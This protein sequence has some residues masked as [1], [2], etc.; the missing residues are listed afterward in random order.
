MDHSYWQ[1]Q[2][3]DKPLFPDLLWSRPENRA[4]AGKL[5]IVGGNAH[6][7]AAAAEAYALANSA[8]A[9]KIRVLL[10][11]A[12]QK[13]VGPMF[14]AGE[15]APSTPSG[16]FAQTALG[17]LLPMAHW[18]DG[19]LLAGD[20]GRN[21]ETAILIEKFLT[22]HPGQ[23]TLTKDAIEY[24]TSQPALV[25]ERANTLLVLSFSQLQKLAVELKF[26]IAFTSG[27]D[28]LRAVDALHE[29][30]G[31]FPFA[32]ITRH[33]DN[34]LVA[35]GGQV[36]STPCK[37]DERVWRLK[38]ASSAAVWRLQNPSKPFEALTTAVA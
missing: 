10:P 13:S 18:A 37:V 1:R 16:S 20:L 3:A 22:K 8:G 29:L 9:G 26:P 2:T 38:K 31:A 27:M 7:F 4:H 32:I 36:S 14:A 17:E 6:G 19:V 11:D 25:R 24:I 23:V 35:I 5:L 21:S 33:L 34:L 15:Y 12:L 30:S 28:L